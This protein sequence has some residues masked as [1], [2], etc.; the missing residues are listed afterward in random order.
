MG[1]AVNPRYPRSLRRF[2]IGGNARGSPSRLVSLLTGIT[3]QKLCRI[4]SRG[5]GNDGEVKKLANFFCISQAL[6]RQALQ[7]G[8][9]H[10][11]QGK[12]LGG[13]DHAF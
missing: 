4:R 13:V 6:M 1:S 11:V 5:W 10:R 7:D 8:A 9:N 12:I 2:L 3:N